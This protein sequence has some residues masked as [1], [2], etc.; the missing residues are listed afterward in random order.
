MNAVLV[1]GVLWVPRRAEAPGIIGDYMTPLELSDPEYDM[2]M[3][4]AVQAPPGTVWPVEDGLTAASWDESEH[5]RDPGGD[6]GGQFVPRGAEAAGDTSGPQGATKVGDVWMGLGPPEN[7]EALRERNKV[8]ELVEQQMEADLKAFL[9]EADL[10]M[11]VPETALEQALADDEFYNQH[12][13]QGSRGMGRS[14]ETEARM[15]GLPEDSGPG[16]LPKYGYLGPDTDGVTDYGPIKVIF[17]DNVKDR[18]TFT[19]ND[20]LMMGSEV[21]PSPVRDPSYLSANLAQ[22]DEVASAWA[23]DP[24]APDYDPT[25]GDTMG[26]N[27]RYGAESEDFIPN[28]DIWHDPI[29]NMATSIP[30]VEAQIYG[31]LTPADIAKVEVLDEEDWDLESPLTGLPLVSDRDS[32]N[33]VLDELSK[34]GIEISYYRPTGDFSGEWA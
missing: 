31:K 25:S 27:E 9:D 32:M 28:G 5:P 15:F 30:Y 34:R 24:D 2:W 26:M 14:P 33:R 20:S 23:I 16:E 10:N 13:A 4:D 22:I 21:V 6:Q 12:Q 1:D 11:R 8:P 19:V 17:K 29:A 18:A 7:Q 3:A